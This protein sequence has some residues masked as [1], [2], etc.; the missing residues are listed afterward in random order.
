MASYSAWISRHLG[1][2]D[3][4]LGLDL[5]VAD[6]QDCVQVLIK[7]MTREAVSR[8]AVAGHA[9]KLLVHLEN[10]DGMAHQSQIVSAGHAGRTTADDGDA[11][12]GVGKALGRLD[13]VSS[14][15]I[16]GELL[17]AANV[18]RGVDKGTTA[19]ALAGMLAD[20]RAGSGER[21]VAT[22]HVDGACVIAGGRKG[23]VGRNVHVSRAQGLAGNATVVGVLACLVL[24]VVLEL[25]CKRLEVLERNV[26]CV[27]TNGAVRKLR[28]H[29]GIGPE[30]LKVFLGSLQVDH[31][32]QTLDHQRNAVIARNAL[33]ARLSRR[34]IQLCEQHLQRT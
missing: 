4:A 7:T 25:A 29:L 23:D 24:H 19:T 10:L 3:V 34:L 12:A 30:L 11:L 18:D 17:N 28:C 32:L 22:D 2:V 21:V 16:D 27:V 8:D 1:L 9:A 15:L 5:D 33:A 14:A 31:L 6:G 20:K 13:R 26:A